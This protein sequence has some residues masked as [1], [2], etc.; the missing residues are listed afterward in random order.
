[1]ST[2]EDADI[3]IDTRADSARVGAGF[4]TLDSNATKATFK[5]L[6]SALNGLAEQVVFTIDQIIPHLAEMQSLLSQRGKARKKV[7]RAAGL[8]SWP[9]Y[10]KAYAAKLECSFRTIQ[11]HITGL[12]RNGKSGPSQSTKNGQQPKRKG[13]SKHSKPWRANAKD[14][15]ALA[16]AQL[17]INDMIAAYEAG[18]DVE[19]AYRQYKKVAVSSAKLDD[20]VAATSDS[21]K[22]DTKAEVKRNLVPVVETAERYI[23]ALEAL[24]HSPSVALKEEQRKALQKPMEGWR[25]VLRYA[26]GVQAER[27]GRSASMETAPAVLKEAA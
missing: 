22:T 16:G 1:M 17:A 7:L 10:G 20:I 27:T 9:E 3:P 21:T 11:D 2:I 19:P 18:V 12:N 25:S 26:R 8:P 24:V 15:R 13:G 14:S 6:D 4:E 23:R 5:R